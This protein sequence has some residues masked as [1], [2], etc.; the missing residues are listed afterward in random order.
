MNTVYARE[1]HLG[2]DEYIDVVV[3]SGLNR[4]IDDRGRVERMLAHANLIVTARQDGRLVGLAR[5]LTTLLLSA[6][7]AVSFYQGIKMPQADN[8]F[9]YRREK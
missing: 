4:P 9:L 5:S 7:T 3:K 2:A 1:D 8:C 6:P